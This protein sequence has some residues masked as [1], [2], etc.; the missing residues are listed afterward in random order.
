MGEA[1]KELFD[2]SAKLKLM[3][4]RKYG[5]VVIENRKVQNGYHIKGNELDIVIDED[6]GELKA[7]QSVLWQVLEYF[8]MQGSKHDPER[9]HIEIEKQA[10]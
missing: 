4:R 9:I 5:Q 1:V 3:S 10:K 8:N 2:E 7:M 6:E